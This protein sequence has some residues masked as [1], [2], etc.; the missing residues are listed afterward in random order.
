MK[1]NILNL[2]DF[3]KVNTLLE[4]FN[5][6]TG[7]VT[8][9]L[10]LEGNVL[11]KSGWRQICTEFHR[12]NP[13]TSKKCTISDTVLAGKMNEGEQYHFYKCL[14]G[15]VDVAVPV[16]IN[17]EHIANLFS[18][19]FFF[20]EPDQMFFKKQAEKYG[21]DEE[22]YLGALAKVP[23]IPRERVKT[24][25]DFL[26]NMTQ[27]ISETTFQKLEQM[28]LNDAVL[29]SEERFKT[30]MEETPVYAYIKD[31][32]L[33]HVFSN[34][35]VLELTQ[36]KQSGQIVDSAKTIF[37]PDIANYLERADQKILSG[38]SN[39]IELEYKVKID[40]QDKWLNDIK[41][42]LKLTDGTKGV[43]GLAFDIT[44]RKRAEEALRASQENYGILF[45]EMQNGFAHS[46]II[47]NA[48]GHPINSRYLAVN[49]AFERITGRKAEDVVGKTIL[50][51]FPS[52]EP[53][54]IETFG[55]VALT[56]EPAHFESQASELGI[57]FDVSAFCPAPNQYAYTFSDISERRKAENEIRRLHTELEQRV[58]ERTAQLEAANK[59]LEAFSYSVSHDLR[60]P[61]RHISGYVDLL[62]NRFRE[63][64][65][66][67]AKHYLNTIAAS[68]SQMGTLIDDLLQFSRTGRQEMCQ[69]AMD[70]NVLVKEVLEALKP[71]F[72]NRN[73]SWT[74]EELPKV[75]GDYSLL[76][77]VWINLLDNAVK[78][79]RNKDEAHIEIGFTQESDHWVFFVR[80]NGVGFDTQYAKKLFGV[81]QRLHSQTDFEGTGIGL[82]NVQRIVHKHAGRV[83]AEAQPD[84]GAT[85]YF[86]IPCG[87]YS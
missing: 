76:K 31:G 62:N 58:V 17:G 57:T 72:L 40:G 81:F 44:E 28:E 69:V 47:C 71:D 49:P 85:F 7:F 11:S 34:K 87:P 80:D 23:V 8:A 42:A 35:K 25:M 10:D 56:G 63:A 68:S 41:F 53:S 14:N 51:V 52:L 22:Q 82:A 86:T 32:S 78:F 48:Q 67:K 3:K 26:Q 84:K 75:F 33:N 15:M 79:T 64:L 46:E 12:I 21:F 29:K 36:L 83:W 13:E 2:I 45:R 9:I 39:R 20:E 19:Q 55:R 70:M 5:K 4:G 38:H 50:E 60:A 74:V 16:V 1:V 6:S 24:A 61:L 77:Q 37:D 43:G 66:D 59:E 73:I 54:W 65:P 30:F 27:L 18:G